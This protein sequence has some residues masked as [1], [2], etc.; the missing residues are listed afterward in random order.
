MQ[1]SF[2]GLSDVWV[3]ETTRQNKNSVVNELSDLCCNKSLVKRCASIKSSLSPVLEIFQKDVGVLFLLHDGM[4]LLAGWTFSKCVL[5]G[6][7]VWISMPVKDKPARNRK[8]LLCMPCCWVLYCFSLLLFCIFSS[9]VYFLT[10]RIAVHLK[11]LFA[12][13]KSLLA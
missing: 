13:I 8:Q 4:S 3:F 5:I 12:L 6:R 1:H 11:H 2:S 10:S 9:N 7:E